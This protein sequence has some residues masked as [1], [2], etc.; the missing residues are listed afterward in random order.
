MQ[1]TVV[2]LPEPDGPMITSFFA[3]GDLKI[4][5]F[6]NVQIAPERR[7]FSLSHQPRSA[8]FFRYSRG[9]MPKCALNARLK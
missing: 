9:V 2:D 7:L 3:L 1:R 8:Y 4:D 5:V 6:Q